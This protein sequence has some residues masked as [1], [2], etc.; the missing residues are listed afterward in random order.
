MAQI[1]LGWAPG[2]PRRGLGVRLEDSAWMSPAGKVEVLAE[3]PLD[4][5]LPMKG[6]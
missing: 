4:L 2:G 1:G 5:V 6:T 3:Y